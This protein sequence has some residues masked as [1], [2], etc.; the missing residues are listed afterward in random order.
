CISKSLYVSDCFLSILGDVIWIED[1]HRLRAWS[2]IA[3]VGNYPI[4]TIGC[5][6]PA[7]VVDNRMIRNTRRNQQLVESFHE[8]I[9][10]F[11]R[12]DA[13]R[14]AIQRSGRRIGY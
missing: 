14:H 10:R 2:M 7:S 1:Y 11:K 9:V 8:P 13:V 12:V 5:V 3:P 4:G 6:A